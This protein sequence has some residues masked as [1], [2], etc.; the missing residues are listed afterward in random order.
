MIEFRECIPNIDDYYNLFITTG[1]NAEYNFTKNNLEKAINN[2]WYS[3][4]IYDFDKLAGFGRVIADG[5][6]HALIVDLIIH[7]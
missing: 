3:V 6:H 7:P 2:S 4:S 1:W 5:V